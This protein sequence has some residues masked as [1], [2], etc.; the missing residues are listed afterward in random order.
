MI[1]I[2]NLHSGT[3]VSGWL[4][5]WG[6]HFLHHSVSKSY[7]TLH[8]ADSVLCNWKNWCILINRTRIRRPAKRHTSLC[9]WRRRKAAA[10]MGL[11]QNTSVN[12]CRLQSASC[13]WNSAVTRV[14]VAAITDVWS[15]NFATYRYLQ[16]LQR[17]QRQNGDWNNWFTTNFACLRKY[18]LAKFLPKYYRKTFES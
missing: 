6:E 15:D 16:G 11:G 17:L 1:I 8:N 14:E 18:I 5:H 4:R 13:R 9:K 2:W 3:N 7:C 12:V 10:W